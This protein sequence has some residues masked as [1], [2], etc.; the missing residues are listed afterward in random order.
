MK[1]CSP[2]AHCQA[3][4]SLLYF[5]MNKAMFCLCFRAGRCT[6]SSVPSIT[7]LTRTQQKPWPETYFHEM[8][9]SMGTQMYFLYWWT[10]FFFFSNKTHFL[11]YSV[12]WNSFNPIS[13]SISTEITY[14]V[15]E[16]FDGIFLFHLYKHSICN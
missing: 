11:I 14:P 6:D 16:A 2:C 3:P 8:M 9:W 12:L 7:K 4:S 1:C 15:W 5:C 10:F 13:A